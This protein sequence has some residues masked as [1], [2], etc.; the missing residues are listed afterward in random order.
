MNA[1]LWCGLG[2]LLALVPAAVAAL[3]TPAIEAVPALQV[4]GVDVSLALIVIA[5]GSG[6]QLFV[7][8]GLVCAFVTF[9]G[10]VAFAVVL[11][12]AER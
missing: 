2:L 11:G 8:L 9:A 6:R 5:V 10:A 3:R 4:A 7:D 12:R 1:W